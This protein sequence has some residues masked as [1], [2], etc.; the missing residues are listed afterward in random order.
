MD[1]RSM[2]EIHVTWQLGVFI[3]GI[4]VLPGVLAPV[5]VALTDEKPVPATVLRVC[6]ALAALIVALIAL[7]IRSRLKQAS[8]EPA[9]DGKPMKVWVVQQV[10]IGLGLLAVAT[11]ILVTLE[12][13]G[14]KVAGRFGV[15]VLGVPG[16]LMIGRAMVPAGRR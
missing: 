11:A 13:T 8:H 7:A 3:A 2:N 9:I 1:Q 4:F 12:L 15:M 16:V 10:G 5:Y 6:L 14:V